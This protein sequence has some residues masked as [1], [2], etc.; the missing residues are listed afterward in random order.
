MSFIQGEDRRFILVRLIVVAGIVG[1][2]ALI[3]LLGMGM[4]NDNLDVTPDDAQEE[5][6]DPFAVPDSLWM[7]DGG[8]ELPDEA[9]LSEGPESS[10]DVSPCSIFVSGTSEAVVDSLPMAPTPEDKSLEALLLVRMWAEEYGIGDDHIDEVYV[11]HNYDTIY[12][13]LPNPCDIDGLKRT[14]ESR[15]IC[16]TRLFPLVAGNILSAYPDGVHLRGVPGVFR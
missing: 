15:F 4:V 5:G 8:T 6:V 14:L 11:F 12:V 16:F 13:D 9:V 10:W 3:A 2:L 7:P 1:I